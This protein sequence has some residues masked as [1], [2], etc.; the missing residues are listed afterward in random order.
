LV[1]KLENFKIEMMKFVNFFTKG[2]FLTGICVVVSNKST[3]EILMIM[4]YFPYGLS[5]SCIQFYQKNNNS[6]KNNIFFLSPSFLFPFCT[7]FSTSLS[8]ILSPFHLYSV[9]FP[10][11]FSPSVQ[12][13]FSLSSFPHLNLA[14]IFLYFALY[15]PRY[16]G[17][18]SIIHF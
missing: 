6:K 10:D 15:L 18:S 11:L 9:F 8:S 13:L 3:L 2:R 14:I 12:Y 17:I 16:F 1:P 5:N 7:S 4:L